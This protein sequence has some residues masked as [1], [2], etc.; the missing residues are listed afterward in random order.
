MSDKDKGKKPAPAD[1]PKARKPY[2]EIGAIFNG[3]EV[4]IF[5]IF[6]L[7]RRTP[8]ICKSLLE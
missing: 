6:S 1:K 3:N 4:K 2:E 7:F 8:R 5:L